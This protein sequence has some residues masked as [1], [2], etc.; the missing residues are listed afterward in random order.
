MAKKCFVFFILAGIILTSCATTTYREKMYADVIGF[1]DSVMLSYMPPSNNPKSTDVKPIPGVVTE[2]EMPYDLLID[3]QAKAMQEAISKIPLGQNTAAIYAL[4][5]G[6]D[7]VISINKNKKLMEGDPNS[8]YYV[9]FFTDGIDNTSVTMAQRSRRGN[10]PQGIAG[11]N[12][13]SAAM[14]T[15]M[16]S[17]LKKYSFFGLI[18]KPN[19]TNTFQ[20]YVLLFQGQ[21]LE[22]YSEEQ[23]TSI[24]D[25]FRA[26]QNAG[27][28][29][30][31]IIDNSMEGLQEKFKDAFVIPSFSFQVPK[32]YVD[33]RV[34]MVLGLDDEGKLVWFEA[35]LK[36][37][38]RSKFLILKEDFYTLE[39]IT[40]SP[41]F[42]FLENTKQMR[43]EMDEVSYDKNANTVP[44]I[45]NDLKVPD[46]EQSNGVKS[47]HVEREYVTQLHD[48]GTGEAKFENTEYQKEGE[49]KK[50]AYILLIMDMSQSLGENAEAARET[51]AWI[52]DYI[53]NQM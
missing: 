52:V 39:D 50:N 16:E 34:R 35:T 6:L 23:L 24:I 49:G 46:A 26:A 32:D 33:Q 11:R 4:D 40:T 2:E 10:Y 12:A 36:H 1:N 27:D 15:R 41:G 8:K 22:S 48:E 53:A 9:V 5:V 44:F 21:D 29:P 19:M 28:A 25:P 18:K 7:R 3:D 51:A 13:Y 30:A 37:Q 31:L 45:I 20:S 43:I 38:Q 14:H 42:S 17:I 47:F